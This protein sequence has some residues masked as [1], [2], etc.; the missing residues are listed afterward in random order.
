MVEIRGKKYKF[1]EADLRAGTKHELEH[2]KDRKIARK[3]ALDHLR[4]HPYYYRVLPMAEQV[5][6]VMENKPPKMKKKRRRAPP[7]NDPM[8]GLP[9]WGSMP[10]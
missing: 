2:T 9:R 8:T 7:R 10:F 4:V 6:V 1:T 5:M 3:T